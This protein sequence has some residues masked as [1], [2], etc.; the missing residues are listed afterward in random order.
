[1]RGLPHRMCSRSLLT[2][3]A[4]NTL[5]HFCTCAGLR[6]RLD[7]LISDLPK[8]LRQSCGTTRRIFQALPASFGVTVLCWPTEYY[9][10]VKFGPEVGTRMKKRKSA[11][12]KV[13][14]WS[15][16]VFRPNQAELSQMAEGVGF[17]PTVGYQPTTVFKTAALSRSAI[18]PNLCPSR[19]RGAARGVAARIQ[20]DN[21]ISALLPALVLGQAQF[22]PRR[23]KARVV[24]L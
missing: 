6:L 10:D 14:N 19:S 9:S 22:I 1:M 20:P 12:E 4:P 15:V 18:P 2:R 23:N 21:R 8:C 24:G 7:N 5:A 3:A 17:E 16:D 11:A 13:S